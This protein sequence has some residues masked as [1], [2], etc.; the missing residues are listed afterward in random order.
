MAQSVTSTVVSAT[1]FTHTELAS[2]AHDVA[3]KAHR[4]DLVEVLTELGSEA[5]STWQSE[6][7]PSRKRELKGFLELR[8]S[9]RLILLI[10]QRADIEAASE[11]AYLLHEESIAQTASA[12]VKQHRLASAEVEDLK[13]SGRMG[14]WTLMAS[15]DPCINPSFNGYAFSKMQGRPSLVFKEMQQS[16]LAYLHVNENQYKTAVNCRK[17]YDSLRHEH[18]REPTERELAD[19]LGIR[20]LKTVRRHLLL[21]E[22]CFDGLLQPKEERYYGSGDTIDAEDRGV[23]GDVDAYLEAQDRMA[24]VSDIGLAL[25][26]LRTISERQSA[27]IRCA[28][29]LEPS[30]REEAIM[31]DMSDDAYR[32]NLSRGHRALRPIVLEL[33]NDGDAYELPQAA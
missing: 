20:G 1:P 25:D 31:A 15:F 26:R 18:G 13:N 27:A 24:A 33:R 17:A 28:Y 32:Q 7:D 11:I 29:G 21:K 14:V 12:L 6:Y 23:F 3:G 30:Q 2:L 10:L 22:I 16:L 8:L 4:L 5:L 19:A 9:D